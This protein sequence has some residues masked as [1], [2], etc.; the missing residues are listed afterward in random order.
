MY[1]PQTNTCRWSG[2]G[3]VV[4]RS[5]SWQYWPRTEGHPRLIGEKGE[6]LELLNQTQDK[7]WERHSS[8]A[9]ELGVPYRNAFRTLKSHLVHSTE[10]L[11]SSCHL[12][13]GRRS[14]E[15]CSQ[16]STGHSG[17]KE[18]PLAEFWHLAAAKGQPGLLPKPLGCFRRSQHALGKFSPIYTWW[19]QFKKY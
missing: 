12:L 9:P 14:T 3:T 5:F 2:G 1:T 18:R 11:G 10:A 19:L 6:C 4:G 13:R 16:H 15:R 8:Q 7:D 17:R